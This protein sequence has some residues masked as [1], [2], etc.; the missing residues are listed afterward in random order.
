M[1]EG[2]VKGMNVLVKGDRV[3]GMSEANECGDERAGEGDEWGGGREEGEGEG[4]EVKVMSEG[5]SEGK[6]NLSG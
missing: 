1:S 4:D 2:K 6:V 5:L 3:K